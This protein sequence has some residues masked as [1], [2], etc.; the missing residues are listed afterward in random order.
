MCRRARFHLLTASW[1]ICWLTGF[2]LTHIP[3]EPKGPV[4]IPHLDKLAHAVLFALITYLGARRIHM[5]TGS[6]AGTAL[7][8]WAAIYLIYAAID[9]LTQPFTGREADLLDWIFDAIGVALGTWAA[10]KYHRAK[11]KR[12]TPLE[13]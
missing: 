8:A 5:K 6:L 9:E 13:M 1:V 2:V 12:E 11:N 4:T 10:W 3:I 7:S